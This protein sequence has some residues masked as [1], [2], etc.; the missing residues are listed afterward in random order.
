MDVECLPKSAP[1][2]LE[3]WQ[4]AAGC[5]MRKSV[6]V[7]AM[8]RKYKLGTRAAVGQKVQGKA[9]E[10]RVMQRVHTYTAADYPLSGAAVPRSSLAQLGQRPRVAGEAAYFYFDAHFQHNAVKVAPGE[11]FVSNE[12]LI[13]VT[14]LGSCIAACL[15]DRTMRIGG[16]NHFMLPDGDSQD[17]S[18]RYGSYAMEL[19]IN[20]MLKLGARRE[21]LQAKIFGGAQVMQSLNLLNVGERNTEF[22]T[23]YLQTE[24]IPIISEDVL[25][26]CPRKLVFFPFTGKAMIKRLGQGYPQEL[27]SQEYQSGNARAVARKTSGGS[28]DLF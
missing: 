16:M 20:K 14:V 2:R 3:S 15:W 13:I 7:G 4:Q 22:V 1:K 28:V 8:D 17:V 26:I 24:R 21:N 5:K 19:L 10:R 18:G 25:G 6:P 12:E 11:Y 23:Q 9:P 27:L